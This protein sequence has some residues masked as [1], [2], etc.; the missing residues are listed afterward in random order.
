[1]T[2]SRSHRLTINESLRRKFRAVETMAQKIAHET[3]NYYGILQGYISLIEVQLKDDE[4]LGEMLN[5]MKEALRSGITLNKRLA[6]FYSSADVMGAEMDL[7]AALT[8]VCATFSR[9]QEFV[10]AVLA[11]E[12]LPSVYLDEPSLRHLAGDLCLLA[13]VTGT[14]PA[15]LELAPR[16]LDEEAIASMVL[17]GRPGDYV[18]LQTRIFLADYPQQEETEFLNPFAFD[19]GEPNG[20]GLAPLYG[21]LRNHGGNL[22]VTLDGDSL[23]LALYFPVQ[24]T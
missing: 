13:K 5:P 8:D 4:K 18:R 11:E 10:V 14:V 19:T 3:N 24:R 22:D 9:E 23:T 2:A 7:A 6:T 20:L 15:R 1:M 21:T 12:A 17:P 16:Q